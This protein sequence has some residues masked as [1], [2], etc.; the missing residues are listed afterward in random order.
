MHYN[1]G[2]DCRRD[3]DGR[4]DRARREKAS[5]EENPHRTQIKGEFIMTK[6]T[7]TMTKSSINRVALIERDERIGSETAAILASA[8]PLCITTMG[9]FPLSLI[10]LGQITRRH[11]DDIL[12]L[13]PK[14]T[15]NATEALESSQ[16]IE[17]IAAL[18]TLI[19]LVALFLIA[20]LP[21]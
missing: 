13:R 2:T 15:T 14:R 8:S 16:Q 6:R 19:A 11:F 5:R 9:A 7:L 18:A 17:M 3:F 21:R 4:S 20:M 1:F 10:A 12:T